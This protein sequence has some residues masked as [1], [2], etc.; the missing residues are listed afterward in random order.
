M[1]SSGMSRGV[2]LVKTDVSEEPSA[3]IIR[4]TRICEL[5]ALAVSS[6]RRTDRNAKNHGLLPRAHT[7]K[8]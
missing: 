4:L 5:G 8:D 6:N 3:S 7:P 2:A 1:A